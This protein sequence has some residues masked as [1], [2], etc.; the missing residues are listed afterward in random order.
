MFRKW[1]NENLS[2]KESFQGNLRFKEDKLDRSL[3]GDETVH[4]WK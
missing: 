3:Q 1:C 2:C 4:D